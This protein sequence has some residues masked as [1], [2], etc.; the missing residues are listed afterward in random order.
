MR[1]EPP[2]ASM[3]PE[4]AAL[5]SAAREASA[6]A[7]C[8]YSR[9]PVGAALRCADGRVFTGCNVENA[10]YGL[11]LCAERVAL[12]AAVAAGARAFTALALVAGRK[13]AA[14]PCGACL[15]V[16]AEFCDPELPVH[17]V[18]LVPEGAP[19]RTLRLKELFP[20]VFRMARRGARP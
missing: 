17:L 1:T 9:F 13:R 4:T 20:Q 16:L 8:P 19:P 14:T 10:S 3:P 7:Y 6:R 11:T 18:P 15:Q 5:L 12:C 2:I